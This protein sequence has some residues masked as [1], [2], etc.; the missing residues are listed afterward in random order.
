MQDRR[1]ELTSYDPVRERAR[2]AFIDSKGR[3][4]AIWIHK[5]TYR[6]LLVGPWDSNQMDGPPNAFQEELYNAFSAS[7][8]EKPMKWL[9]TNANKLMMQEAS[10][11]NERQ[12]EDV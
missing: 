7:I 12:N 1:V 9:E 2:I 10:S 6:A 5:N 11:K 4:T 8:K 3:P